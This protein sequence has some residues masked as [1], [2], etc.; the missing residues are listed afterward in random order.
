MASR[1]SAWTLMGPHDSAMRNDWWG[2]KQRPDGE[3]EEHRRTR[4]DTRRP[5]RAC[6]NECREPW[7]IL[8][9]GE[10]SLASSVGCERARK[11]CT[12]LESVPDSWGK[13][14]HD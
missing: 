4:A 2:R 13:A 11:R 12:A 10:M 7:G 6:A 5:S 1:R 9:Y 3:L 8:A 14:S